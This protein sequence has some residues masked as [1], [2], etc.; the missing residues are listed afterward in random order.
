MDARKR[1]AL[2]KELF[3]VD[4]RGIGISYL[5]ISIGSSDLNDHVYSYDDLAAGETDPELAKFSLGPD[6]VELISVEILAINPGIAILGSPWL[7]P[8]RMKTNGNAK[9][10]KLETEYH[11]SYAKYFVKYIHG[12]KGEAINVAAI[13]IQNE[14]MN[15]KNTPN[16]LMMAEEE[17]LFYQGASGTGVCGGG[18]KD[19]DHSLR[20]QLRC[21][22]VGDFDSE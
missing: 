12:M 21:S 22:G 7:A 1:A 18:D 4:G 11:G 10:G 19:E 3:S 13:T 8:A 14:P 2:L 6:R 15:D 17:A 9:G 20:S 5:R 16:M